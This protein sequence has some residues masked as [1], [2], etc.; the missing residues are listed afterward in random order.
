MLKISHIVKNFEKINAL[1]NV[2]L[3]IKQ[4]EFFGLL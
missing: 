4:G 3:N 2:S 1:K